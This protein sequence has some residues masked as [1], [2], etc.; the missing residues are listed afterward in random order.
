[1]SGVATVV[2]AVAVPLMMTLVL[3]DLFMKVPMA[4]AL[5]Q[6]FW[7]IPTVITALVV[8]RLNPNK[9]GA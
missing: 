1:M 9:P 7:L 8:S 2:N 3:S 6:L 5:C 4:G